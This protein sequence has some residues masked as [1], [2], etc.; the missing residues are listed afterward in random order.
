MGFVLSVLYFVTYYLTPATLFGPLAACSYRA[1]SCGAGLSCLT[2][3]AD[4]IIHSEDTAVSGLD[5]V[6][7]CGHFVSAHRNALGR[8]SHTGV[9]GIYSE[10]FRIFPC[11][12]ALQLE[13]EVADSCPDDAVCLPV[14]N[15][16][17]VHR[18]APWSSGERPSSSRGH[19]GRRS[20]SVEH[21]APLSSCA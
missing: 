5:R 7:A 6:G 4:E 11:V 20:E 15:C 3:C 19:R 2:A 1:D 9:S 14:C 21:G 16:T 18:S 13:E 8:G 17:R 10:C 12:L